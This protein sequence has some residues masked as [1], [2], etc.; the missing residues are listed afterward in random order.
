M[1]DPARLYAMLKNNDL[2][3]GSSRMQCLGKPVAFMELNKIFVELFKRSMSS[4][5]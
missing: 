2:V 3:F 5:W 1:T 4:I